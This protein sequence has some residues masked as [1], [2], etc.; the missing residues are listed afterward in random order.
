[1]QPLAARPVMETGPEWKG[2]AGYLPYQMIVSACEMGIIH[3]PSKIEDAQFQP[4]SLDLRLGSKAYRIQS[5]FLPENDT[6]ENK[7][8][9]L[10][11]YE[12]DLSG[13][14]GGILER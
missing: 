14:E 9:D 8:K 6:V 4:V 1:M 3:A 12:V 11:Q 2:K 5:S 10:Q 13:P 7:L